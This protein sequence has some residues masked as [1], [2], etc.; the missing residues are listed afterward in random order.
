MKFKKGHPFYPKN[1]NKKCVDCKKHLRTNTAK[2]CRECYLKFISI[3]QNTSNYGKHFSEEHKRKIGEAKKKLYRDPS[4][5]PNWKGGQREDNGYIRILNR[6]H[7]FCDKSG[8]IH[9]SHL[10]MEQVIGRYLKPEEVVH[11]I[12]GIRN[13]DRPENLKLFKNKGEHSKFHIK[14]RKRSKFGP[15]I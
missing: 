13:D 1:E 14:Q 5:N 7:P 3:P 12:N 15:L 9:H 2:R 10:V 4:N 11:H 8:C 6:K